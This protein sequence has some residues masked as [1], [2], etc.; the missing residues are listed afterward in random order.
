MF[1]IQHKDMTKR[2]EL[3]YCEVVIPKSRRS[4]MTNKVW[5]VRKWIQL[6]PI[7]MVGEKKMHVQSYTQIQ[8]HILMDSFINQV[9]KQS[10]RKSITLEKHPSEMG[11]GIGTA[12]PER[13]KIWKKALHHN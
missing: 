10:G 2:T 4:Q 11:K 8:K 5:C 7:T 13:A 9:D 1:T 3:I 6:F 12:Y